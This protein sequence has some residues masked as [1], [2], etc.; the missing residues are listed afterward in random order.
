VK[1]LAVV[2]AL[3]SLTSP[4]IAQEKQQPPPLGVPKDFAI[5]SPRRFTLDNGLPV[6]MVT[7][8]QVPKVTIRLVVS[9]ANLH[10]KKDEVWLADLTGSLM[11]QGT[12]TLSAD[13]LAREFATMG[14]E[15]GVSVGSDTTTINT[16]VLSE[17]GADAVRLIAD[18]AQRPKLPESELGRLKSDLLRT[19]SIQRSTPQAIAQEKFAELLYGDHPY[20]RV[21]PQ[22]AALKA[23]TIDQVR[24]FHRNNFNATRARLYVAGVFDAAALEAAVRAAFGKWER[25]SAAAPPKI[26]PADNKRFGFLDRADAPQSTVLLGLRVPDPTHKDWVALEVTNS[27]LGGA[28]ISR[29]TSNIREDKGYTYSPNSAVQAHPGDASWVETADVTTKATGDSLKEIFFEIDRL[30]KEAPP[31]TELRSIQNY[32]AGIFVVQNASRSGVIGR[33]AFV[34]LHGLGDDYLTSYVKRVMAVTPED[35]RRIA[36]EYLVPEKMTLVV[37]GDPKTVKDQLTPWSTR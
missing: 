17:R 14:G 2:L 13:A 30:R 3:L 15:L 27:L 20:G 23:F 7:F 34:D 28:F 37:L 9:A 35:V 10:E 22:E 25:G 1:R 32:L 18:V 16:D 5:P 26:P 24:A 6:T 31:A 8:G 21:F 19:L 4:A 33:L 36:S 12:A 29:I 11:E